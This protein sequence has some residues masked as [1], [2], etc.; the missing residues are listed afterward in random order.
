AD[1]ADE[2]TALI[3]ERHRC[4]VG[5]MHRQ[6]HGTQRRARRRPEHRTVIR[7]HRLLGFRTGYPG[8]LLLV[9]LGIDHL[10][11]GPDL[12]AGGAPAVEPYPAL[13]RLFEIA[14]IAH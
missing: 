1:G 8:R 9:A 4:R 12:E 3:E 11:V 5:A 7:A 2:A 13:A 6:H 14:R 10:A